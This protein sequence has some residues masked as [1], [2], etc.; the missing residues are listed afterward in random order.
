M[1]FFGEFPNAP[2]HHLQNEARQ[3]SGL[4]AFCPVGLA[5]LVGHLLAPAPQR[6]DVVGRDRFSGAEIGPQVE[7]LAPFSEQLTALAKRITADHEQMANT[8]EVEFIG[9]AKQVQPMV[10]VIVARDG[11]T[12]E[13]SGR[14]PF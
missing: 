8:F 14:R 11:V 4:P 10:N 1:R 5:A 7:E 3:S 12:L 6:H 2:S 9:D 13:M